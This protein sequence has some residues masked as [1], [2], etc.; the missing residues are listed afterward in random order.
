MEDC[1]FCKIV[2]GEIPTNKIYEDEHT[3]AFNDINPQAPTH[4]LVIPKEHYEGIHEIPE[5]HI[6][7]LQHLYTTVGKVVLQEGLIE[8]G[9]RL[10]VNFGKKSGQEVPHIHVH[11]LSGRQMHWPPG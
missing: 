7:I 6:E 10:V 4:L 8:D 11:I 1:I 5:D 2:K 9:Y 3:L